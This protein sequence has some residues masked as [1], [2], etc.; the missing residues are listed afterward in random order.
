MIALDVMGGDH[1]PT[2]TVHGALQAAKKNIPI[3]LFGDEIQMR[4][5]LEKVDSAW[6]S[7]PVS[8]F[9]CSQTIAMGDEPTTSILKKTDASLVRALHA[10][11][12]GTASAVVSAGNTGAAL[13]GGIFILGRAEGILRPALGNFLPT[14]QGSIF[15]IDLGANTDCKPE[16][17]E[18]FAFMGHVYVKKVKGIMQ[19]R[20]ALLSNGS[21]PYKGS[22]ATKKSYDR[23]MMAPL[24]FVGNLESRDIFDDA[25]D[26]LVCDGFTGN[27][28]LKAIQGTAKAMSW[29][30]KDEAERLPW[31]RKLLFTAGR[32]IF[33]AL[34]QKT[35][36]DDKG[37]ALLLGL[38]HP[39]IVAHGCANAQAIERAIIMAHEYVRT[40]FVP[41]FNNEVA[42]LLKM[43]S[44]YIDHSVTSNG[45][46][47]L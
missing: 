44:F 1:A 15:C 30:I 16:F 42:D 7:Y 24:N 38:K 12:D 34:R 46:K 22:M 25:A 9:N 8:L 18:Q 31:Y 4:A 39:L 29:W 33:S 13:V 6:S 43:S 5:L 37:G 45:E 41:T 3:G 20:V 14:K 11:A 28:M 47:N 40:D 19:P 27:I 17:L 35:S 21:E 36:Y 23:L 32:P 10:V 26:V 2:V